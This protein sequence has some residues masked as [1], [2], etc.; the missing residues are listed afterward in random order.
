MDTDPHWKLFAL[1]VIHPRGSPDGPSEMRAEC[2]ITEVEPS[3]EVTVRFAQAI[4]RQVITVV[5][6]PVEELI[7]TG[8]RYSTGEETLERE[9]CLSPLP[10]RTAAIRTAGSERMELTENGVLAGAQVW[11]WEPQHGTVEAWTEEVWPG[12]CR[13]IAAAA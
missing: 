12:L 8:S 4:E 10:N 1:G 9:I 6:T 2:L 5:G 13:L 3:L 11:R 7:A